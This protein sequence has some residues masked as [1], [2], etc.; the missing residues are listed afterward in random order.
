M[1]A[2]TSADLLRGVGLIADGP[3][4]W[5]RRVRSARPGVYLIEA[6]AAAE[7]APLDLALV[8]KWLERATGLLLDGARPTSKELLARVA[9]DWL[10]GQTVL[11][12]GSAAESLADR[13]EA[14]Q[15]TLP[16]SP[17]PCPDGLRLHLLRGVENCRVWWAETEAPEEYED[18]L[19]DAFAAAVGQQPATATGGF[20]APFAVLRRP[21]GEERPTGITGSLAAAPLE[22]TGIPVRAVGSAPGGRK[23]LPATPPRPAVARTGSTAAARSGPGRPADAPQPPSSR[24]AT[25][26]AAH[27]TAAAAASPS[28]DAFHLST[29]GRARLEAELAELRAVHRPEVVR[30]VAAAR[31]HGD[32]SENAEYH[33]AREELGFLDGRIRALEARLLAAVTVD[34]VGEAG[35]ATLGSVVVVETGGEEHTL[36]LVGSAEADLGSGRI[37]VASPV[38]RALL[39]AA[40]GQEV[41][42][43]TPA[44]PV[45][46]RVLKVE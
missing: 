4:I 20:V 46:Y 16:G 32:L 27:P 36:R 23:R 40:S 8:G 13:V 18:A 15:A 45:T 3:V 11:F 24:P 29:E 37:S 5:G 14:L 33:A 44:G 34:A 12:I 7:R 22:P 2:A 26:S 19:L 38:G 6:P 10:A 1:T 42:V 25:G 31:E 43:A 41:T 21:T 9:R 35:R 39:G 17:L 28:A 30:R